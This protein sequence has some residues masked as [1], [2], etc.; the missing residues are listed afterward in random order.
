MNLRN[1][2]TAA[3]LIAR[4]ALERAESRGSHYRSDLPTPAPALYNVYVRAEDKAGPRVWTEPVR[5]TPTPPLRRAGRAR[6][7]RGR[8]LTRR[9]LKKGDLRRYGATAMPW[10]RHFYRTGELSSAGPRRGPALA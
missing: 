2:A 10:Q 5:L 9:M 1:Q 4:S 8:G 7:R 3:W 6:R